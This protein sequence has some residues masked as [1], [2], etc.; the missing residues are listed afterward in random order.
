MNRD[1]IVR[2]WIKGLRTLADVQL[3]L[4]GLTVLIGENSTGKSSIIEALELLRRSVS[5]SLVQ[6][7]NEFHLGL[8]ALL[9]QG[10]PRLEL[11]LETRG[12]GDSLEYH[13]ALAL[14]GNLPRIIEEQLRHTDPEGTSTLLL[15][16]DLS[17]SEMIVNEEGGRS[18]VDADVHT[19]VL[20]ALGTLRL[21]PTF[22]RIKETLSSLAIH[23]PFD[24]GAGWGAKALR[25]ES[26][27]REA[28][29]IDGAQVLERHGVN[30]ANVWHALQN[31]FGEAHWRETLDYVRLGLGA[32]VESVVVSARLGSGP[33]RV[34]LGLKYRGFEQPL[35]ALA[36]SDGTLAYL[37]FVALFRLHG[38]RTLLA[39]DEPEHHFHPELLVRVVGLFEE[40]A[41][42]SPVIVATHSDRLLDAL[43]TPA[44]SVVLCEL[45][46]SRATE[47]RRPDAAELS[48]WLEDYG[49]YGALRAAGLEPLVMQQEGQR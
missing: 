1:T 2:V 12:E 5:G 32:D 18:Q 4:N 37:C 16:R 40:L 43:T 11:G 39:F 7:I 22:R 29:Q 23:L 38:G 36:L 27:L 26:P 35:P 24:V 41:Q 47:L 19:T 44:S 8:P 31:D 13:F 14:E 15:S 6:Q 9:R 30:L 21:P 42:M 33:G 46:E 10:A 17:R 25:R 49:G 48:H 28:A 45:N 20:H 34:S 3:E